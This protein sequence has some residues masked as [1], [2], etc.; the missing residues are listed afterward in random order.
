MVHYNHEIAP[1]YNISI[2]FNMLRYEDIIEKSTLPYFNM[3]AFSSTPYHAYN[4]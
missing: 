3:Y 2:P 1:L 4:W